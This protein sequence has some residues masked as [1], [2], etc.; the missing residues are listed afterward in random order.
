MVIDNSEAGQQLT[1]QEQEMET[2]STAKA[3][4]EPHNLNL[5]TYSA[6]WDLLGDIPRATSEH[7]GEGMQFKDV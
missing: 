7:R 4:W 5:S 6:A 2:F 3:T 1:V